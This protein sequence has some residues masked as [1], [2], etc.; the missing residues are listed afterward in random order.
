[1]SS[2]S[3]P[4]ASPRRASV[5]KMSSPSQPS[6]STMGT[7][8]ASSNFLTMGNCWRKSLSMGG[9]CALYCGSISMRTAGRPLSN[10]QITPSGSKASTIL[11]NMLR[12]PKTAL[13]GRPSGA[14]MVGGTAWNAR[15]ISEL[16]SMTATTRRRGADAVDEET[17]VE[18]SVIRP[19]FVSF[20]CAPVYAS[21]TLGAISHSALPYSSA[22][23]ANTPA[24]IEGTKAP[25]PRDTMACGNTTC[26]ERKE[27]HGTTQRMEEI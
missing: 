10:A 26:V 23:E 8:M 3:Q 9:R 11:R 6:A 2:M 18:T 1:M 19:S 22:S 21:G 7:R 5:P 12:K 17:S 20:C 16:P 15:C 14:F 4:A 24:A 25:R 13:V 27:R